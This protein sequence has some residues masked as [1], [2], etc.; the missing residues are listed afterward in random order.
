MSETV[1][2]KKTGPAERCRI[3]GRAGSG[4]KLA[5]LSR[6]EVRSCPDCGIVFLYPQPDHARLAE[7]HSSKEYNEHPYFEKRRGMN[8]P[9][10]RAHRALIDRIRPYGPFARA[11]DIGCSA[12]ELMHFL[13]RELG[14]E[15]HGVD[16]SP[17]AVE[18]IPKAK[19][20]FPLCADVRDAD[21]ESASFDLIAMVDVIEH[22]DDPVSVMNRVFELLKPGGIVYIHTLN[23]KSLI[24]RAALAGAGASRALHPFVERL[25]IDFHPYYFDRAS[26]GRLVAGAG[27]TIEARFD[28]ELDMRTISYSFAIKAGLLFFYSMQKL[29]KDK[30]TQT[31][32]AVKR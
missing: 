9:V 8:A 3:C 28:Q 29:M 2:E 16:V 1:E 31:I 32:I 22:V 4:V 5:A 25:Y 18:S 21:Y 15:C 26:L 7:L 27:F 19:G 10:E 30:T 6:Y 17:L 20:V 23:Q 11:L 24:Y 13:R 12:G 14:C